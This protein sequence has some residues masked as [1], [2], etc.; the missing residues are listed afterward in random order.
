V[1]EVTGFA[2]TFSARYAASVATEA[3]FAGV[4]RLNGVA[5]QLQE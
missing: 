5:V 3:N 4:R 1:G 2:A